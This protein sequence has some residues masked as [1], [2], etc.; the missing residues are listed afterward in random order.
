MLAQISQF[1][2]DDANMKIY[3]NG[4]YRDMTGK[5]IAAMQAQFCRAALMERSRPLTEA[6]VSRMV[7]ARQINDLT[8]DDNTALRMKTFYPTFESIVGQTVEQGFKFTHGDKL[9]RVLQPGLTIQANYTPG[10]GTESLYTQVNEIHAGTQE[11]PIPY[12]GN[13]ALEEGLHYI[14]DYTLY[15]CVRSTGN[16]V[17]QPLSELSAFAEKVT[18]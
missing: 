13:L 5:E 3:D 2:G 1:T 7:I 15:R 11:D 10:A 6:E 8:V 16:P 17:Y 14:Q 12:E 9:W 18:F 4:T